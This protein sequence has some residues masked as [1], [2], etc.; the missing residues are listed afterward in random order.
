MFSD[1]S[2]E[3]DGSLVI[4]FLL[5]AWSYHLGLEDLGRLG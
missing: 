2:P 4:R 3:T 1:P 5:L